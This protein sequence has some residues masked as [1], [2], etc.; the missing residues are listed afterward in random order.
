[1]KRKIKEKLKAIELRERGFSLNEILKEINASKSSVS[2]WVRNVR[3]SNNARKRLLT[4]IKLGQLISAENKRKRT[5]DILKKYLQE[6]G[7]EIEKRSLD[8]V[9]ARIFCSL[10]YWCEGGKSHFQ[11]L[12]FTNSDPHLVRTFLFLLRKGFNLD[13]GKFRPCIHLHKYHNIKSQINFW[14]KITK[15]PKSQFI[16]P[17]LKLNTGKRI[18]KDYPGCI[19][20]RYHS[21]DL[22][23]QILMTAEAF[24]SKH[25]GV[26]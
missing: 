11:G 12:N 22:A 2:V 10:L 9:A 25:G 6:A 23:R 4:K 20:I 18:R 8:R 13:E 14:S 1:M 17:F 3:L 15:I 7:R 16:K 19:G 24:L 5:E 26:G 21:N